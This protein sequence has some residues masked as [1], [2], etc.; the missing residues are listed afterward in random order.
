MA[1]YMFQQSEAN[2]PEPNTD[3][4][5]PQPFWGKEETGSSWQL[6][7][8]I[9][10]QG[11]LT[12]VHSNREVSSTEKDQAN[13]PSSPVGSHTSMPLFRVSFVGP[14]QRW[15]SVST[16]IDQHQTPQETATQLPNTPFNVVTGPYQTTWE[17]ANASPGPA[18]NTP[19]GP[20]QAVWETP[21]IHPDPPS[22]QTPPAY[23]GWQRVRK[24][25]MYP[26][27]Q[28]L[29]H[30][31]MNNIRTPNAEKSLLWQFVQPG[32]AG[33]TNGSLLILAPIFAVAFATHHPSTVFLVGMASALGAGISIAF[34]EAFSSDEITGLDKSFIRGGIAGL[35]TVLSGFGYTLPFLIPNIRLALFLSYGVVACELLGIA[36]VRHKFFG[37]GWLR[38]II[39]VVGCGLLV[40]MVAVLL[41][42]A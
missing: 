29:A 4:L 18:R 23:Q 10:S 1:D 42:N 24:P 40:L 37:T 30:P 27:W 14:D 13:T 9:I 6:V 8:P 21:T 7:P 19:T 2:Y 28:G 26:S 20:R 39:Q 41:G 38:S 34:S 16:M 12:A 33:L 35:M 5:S 17:V 22:P 11:R 25:E 3:S 32:L 15:Y 36:A 31:A